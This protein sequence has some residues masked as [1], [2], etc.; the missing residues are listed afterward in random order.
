[1]KIFTITTN[2]WK[3]QGKPWFF[4][5][6][7]DADSIE[8][9]CERLSNGEI[10]AGNRLLLTDVEGEEG[11]MIRGREPMGLGA[12]QAGTVQWPRQ[13]IWEPQRQEAS[14]GDVTRAA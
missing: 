12:P 14:A 11:A 3:T 1:M 8:E 9:L 10:I 2:I 6:E 7:C 5:F 13:R 4:N